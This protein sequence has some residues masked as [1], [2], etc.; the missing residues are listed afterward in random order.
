MGYVV[1]SWLAISV[2]IG[3]QA[4][5]TKDRWSKFWGGLTFA[6]L[7]VLYQL[8]FPEDVPARIP[9]ESQIITLEELTAILATLTGTP[10]MF[11][12][13]WSL[14]KVHPSGR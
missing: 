3:C 8:F 14:P 10:L 5:L 2:A 12:I 1:L 13:V 11:L 6:V 9:E 7:I 4:Q